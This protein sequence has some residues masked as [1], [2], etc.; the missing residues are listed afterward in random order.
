M[1]RPAL[2]AA[3]PTTELETHMPKFM[4]KINY[5]VDGAKGVIKDGGTARRAVAQKAAES[6][7]GRVEAF[8]FALGDT[9]A[10]VIGDFPDAASAAAIA[11]TVSASGGASAQTVVLLTP[12]EMD[13]AA[14]KSPMYTPP[15][16]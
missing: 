9:D 10:Y 3:H 7:D 6:V 12:E 1:M 15:G 14:R 8:Y 13:A 16:R 5:T 2:G 4:L 11:M